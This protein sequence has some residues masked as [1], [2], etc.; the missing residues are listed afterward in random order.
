M[1]FQRVSFVCNAAYETT[2][3]YTLTSS[4]A[5]YIVP[6]KD[7]NSLELETPISNQTPFGQ[8][9]KK[10]IATQICKFYTLKAT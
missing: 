5:D 6:P 4:E 8:L 2:F 9:Q 3:T 10:I 7:F 1:F